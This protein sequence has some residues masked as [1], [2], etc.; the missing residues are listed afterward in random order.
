MSKPKANSTIT[1]IHDQSELSKQQ[2][3]L[4]IGQRVNPQ[5]PHYN[6]VFAFFL[7]GDLHPEI[8]RAAWQRIVD[9]SE[10]LRMRIIERDGLPG[11]EF[12]PSGSCG[13][14]LADF[15]SREDP[16][17][18]F[19]KWARARSGQPLQMEKKL[20]DSVL[21]KLGDNQFGWYLNQHHLITDANSTLLLYRL[22]MDLYHDMVHGIEAD[23]PEVPHPYKE[24]IGSLPA[25]SGENEKRALD[26]LRSRCGEAFHRTR[27]WGRK[28]STSTTESERRT[29]RLDR[30]Q[31]ETLRR[32]SREGP[33]RSVSREISVFTVFATLTSSFL[34]L[35]SG[36]R[37]IRFDA[38][39]QNRPTPQARKALGLF[40][41]MLP[42]AVAIDEE[43]TFRTLGS[44]CLTEA[45]DFLKNAVPGISFLEENAASSAVLN[46]FPASFKQ[47]EDIAMEVEWIHSGHIDN[48][49]GF[50]LQVHEF[51]GDGRFTLHLDL[52]KAAFPERERDRAVHIFQTLL[53]ALLDNLDQSLGEVDLLDEAERKFLLEGFNRTSEAPLPRETVISHFLQQAGKSPEAIAIRCGTRTLTYRQLQ[54]RVRAVAALLE[55]QDPD[56]GKLVAIYMR[57]SVDAVVGIMAVL[58]TGRAYV[59]VDPGYPPTRVA[60]ILE[61]CGASLVLSHK[62]LGKGLEGTGK[63]ILEVD[64]IQDNQQEPAAIRDPA[65]DQLAYMIYTSGSTGNPKGVPIRHEGLTDYLE[66]ASRTYVRGE[67]L[68]FPLFTSLSFDLTVTSLFLPLITGGTLVVYEEKDGPLDSGIIEVINDNA[69]DIIKLTPSHLSLLQQLELGTSRIRRMILGGE[70]LKAHLAKTITGQFGKPVEIYNE[71]GPTEAV[72]GCMIHRYDPETD[73]GVSVPIGIPADHVQLYVV[74]QQLHLTPPGVPGELCISRH[75][76]SPGYHNQPELSAER[77]IPH[78]FRDGV[79]LYR[80]GDLVRFNERGLLEYL[81][82]IDRQLKLSGYRIEPGEIEQ[83]M[84]AHEDVSACVV[85]TYLPAAR[86]ATEETVTYCARCG[87]PSNYPKITFDEEGVCGVCHTYD[88]IRERAQAYFKSM[89]ELEARFAELKK[90]ADGDYD[91]LVLLSGGKDS[92]YSLCRLVDMGLRIFA[93]TLDN[94]YISDQA[95]GNIRKVVSALGVDHEFA[96]TPAMNAIFKDSLIRFSNVCNGCFK[97]IYTLSVNK[98]R[99]LGIPAIVTGLSRG[100]F[101]ETRL[102]EHLFQAGRFSPEDIDRAVLEARKV[103]HQTDDAVTRLLDTSAFDSDQVFEE[104]TFVDFYRYHEVS[105]TEMMAYLKE[106][107][108][109]ERPSDTGRSTN[110]LVNDVGIYIH[111]KERGFHNYALPYSWD[112]RMGHKTREQAIDELNDALDLQQVRSMLDEIEYDEDRLVRQAGQR[113]LVAYYVARQPVSE[114]Q[115][116]RH[117]AGRLPDELIPHRLVAVESI[118]LSPNGKADLAALPVPDGRDDTE[119]RPH[120]EPDGPVETQI[121][122]IWSAVLGV[123]P[124]SS[125]DSFFNL[126]GTS[127]AAM[128][129]M[130]RIC[131]A[132]DMDLPLQTVFQYTTVSSLAACVEEKLLEEISELSDEEAELL[133]GEGED[134]A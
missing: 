111:N 74:N 64:R 11:V 52:G 59:P 89:P 47:Y 90:Q 7:E 91:A 106:R 61:D 43:E 54:E 130:L 18:D 94:G 123:S 87:L 101:F 23:P 68:A 57:R 79:R 67:T 117:L 98:A 46:F 16:R 99:E 40:I 39:V 25:P 124:I 78:P 24:A 20:V 55:G 72:V 120:V 132:F 100:Q 128:E 26:H 15:S 37:E 3:Q 65:L 93:Y 86:V 41:E 107:V 56:P 108:G 62:G 81:G 92:T 27:F 5:S 77:F 8:L 44:K 29:I 14:Q 73:T 31:S 49:H 66:W 85:T 2:V 84:V 83:A 10:V 115:L 125:A 69:V 97:T 28:D 126:G 35:V 134:P 118:P 50:R 63:R 103:Y 112:V 110:C 34:H 116:R 102:T 127:L 60:Y 19:R 122:E 113:R 9:G 1:R 58:A 131:N 38:P 36:Q 30:E 105:L 12:N 70:D 114:G 109:W 129:V 42:F 133:L 45:Y 119:D 53:L 13:M 71:Y 4:W 96:T 82:R 80:T 21:V 33:F 88:A 6:M 22:V 76:L 75:G 17:G 104:I 51:N 121:A 32:I 48:V 95:K